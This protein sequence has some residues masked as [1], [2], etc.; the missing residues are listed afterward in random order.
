MIWTSPQSISLILLEM[1]SKVLM[2]I[3]QCFALQIESKAVK[4]PHS[5]PSQRRIYAFEDLPNLETQASVLLRRSFFILDSASSGLFQ[6]LDLRCR[7][8]CAECG[9]VGCG[10]AGGVIAPD[11]LKICRHH[12]FSRLM[13]NYDQTVQNL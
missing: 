10:A 9:P 11:E 5:D 2:D 1:S 12:D 4:G 7:A 13:R 6:A 8:F 3:A